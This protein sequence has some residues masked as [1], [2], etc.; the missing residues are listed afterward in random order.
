MSIA[1]LTTKI[2]SYIWPKDSHRRAEIIFKLN[3]GEPLGFNFAECKY[4]G[5]NRIYSLDDFEFLR[6]LANE[7]LRLSEEVK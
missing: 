6:D 7:I 1:T 3:I 5:V 4:T 2:Y